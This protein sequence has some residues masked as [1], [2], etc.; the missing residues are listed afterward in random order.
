MYEVPFGVAADL[1][2]RAS[3]CFEEVADSISRATD[4][5]ASIGET[6]EPSSFSSIQLDHL[7]SM[8]DNLRLASKAIRQ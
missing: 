1:H 2:D 8:S 4:F 6:Y 3:A 5:I 7:E